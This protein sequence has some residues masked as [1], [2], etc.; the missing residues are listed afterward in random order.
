[1]SRYNFAAAGCIQDVASSARDI[2]HF[3]ARE[4]VRDNAVLRFNHEASQQQRHPQPKPR[5]IE[6]LSAE[7]NG[8]QRRSGFTA[9]CRCHSLQFDVKNRL[10]GCARR[11]TIVRTFAHAP[12]AY[13]ELA[14]A[15]GLKN[16][17]RSITSP[18]QV[19]QLLTQFRPPRTGRAVFLPR[20]YKGSRQSDAS[21]EPIHRC[22]FCHEV[23]TSHRRFL[24][25]RRERA[26]C[27]TWLTPAFITRNTRRGSCSE[28]H[29]AENASRLT[30][31]A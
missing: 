22:A 12:G 20:S 14:V 1:M 2:R 5:S 6:L 31:M 26:A 9:H 4:N 23:E 11:R 3:N 30:S 19:R 8:V 7:A 13:A 15:S 25:R 16:K 29:V 18:W 24:L 17:R 27:R 28:C 10:P 21:S